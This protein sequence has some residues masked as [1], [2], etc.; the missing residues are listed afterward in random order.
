MRCAKRRHRRRPV[1]ARSMV[2]TLSVTSQPGRDH[3][4]MTGDAMVNAMQRVA[5]S[6]NPLYIPSRRH[7]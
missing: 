6:L 7:E 3:M 5:P 1:G 2:P 4:S